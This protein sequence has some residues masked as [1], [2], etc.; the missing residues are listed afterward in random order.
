MGAE[1]LKT[2][3]KQLRNESPYCNPTGRTATACSLMA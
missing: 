3:G 2:H 1:S